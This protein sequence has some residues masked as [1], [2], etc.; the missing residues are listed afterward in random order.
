P[1]CSPDLTPL[2]FLLWGYLKSKVYVT[3]PQ[4]LNDLRGRITREIELIPPFRNAVSAVYNRLAHCQ[5]VEG[6]QF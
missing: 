3:K 5:A 1:L 4:D 2:D 6:Q